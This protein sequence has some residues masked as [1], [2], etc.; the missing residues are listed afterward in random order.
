MSASLPRGP[1]RGA[2][3]ERVQ[4]YVPHA[5]NLGLMGGAG[6]AD[7]CILFLLEPRRAPVRAS[8]AACQRLEPSKEFQ[9][10][11][12]NGDRLLL[13]NLDSLLGEELAAVRAG[14]VLGSDPRRH[15]R[16]RL[17]RRRALHRRSGEGVGAVVADERAGLLIDGDE[18]RSAVG[19][20][21]GHLEGR[22]CSED[23]E[24]G[25]TTS[26]SRRR[27]LRMGKERRAELDR[28][29]MIGAQPLSVRKS[30]SGSSSA[31]KTVQDASVCNAK[32]LL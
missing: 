23:G 5:S 29:S 15:G 24:G 14:R 1:G 26:R 8:E 28:I 7:G 19:A 25:F 21:G 4:T 30:G 2:Q 6:G 32:R 12:M 9:L 16:G 20:I 27:W 3:S 11:R 22:G 31:E 10:G 13:V 17:R 18:G